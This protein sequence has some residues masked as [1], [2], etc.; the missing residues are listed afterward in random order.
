MVARLAQE[1]GVEIVG[2]DEPLEGTLIRQEAPRVGVYQSWRPEIDEGWTRL[3]FERFE[4]PYDTLHDDDI[5]QGNLRQRFD[6]ILLPQQRPA[7]LLNGNPEKN[8]YKEPYPPEY[9]GGLGPVG[10][11]ALRAFAEAGGTIVALDS[12]SE[13]AIQH[14][15]LPVKNA[16]AGVAEEDFYCPGSL[17][18]VVID[19]SHPIGYG[20]PRDGV[21]L[22]MK[23][24]VF[25]VSGPGA[26]E[27]DVPV[28]YP[29]VAQ[30]LS[31]WILGSE[32][33]AG[34]AAVVDVPVGAGRAVLIGFRPQFRAQ[35]RGTYKIL[36]NAVLSA[37][38][39]KPEML[40]I[41]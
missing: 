38:Q 36:F 29:N 10:A 40:R 39:G 18:R 2:L 25:E 7:D 21:A 4:L 26:G 15:Y 34:K 20:M 31:G 32:K 41:D 33:L 5:R 19:T 12:S 8:K 13:F 6:V 23:S 28:S 24:P 27:V 14:L 17:L 30:N 9:V 11:E 1:T 35:A 3:I 16:V 37:A 22:F